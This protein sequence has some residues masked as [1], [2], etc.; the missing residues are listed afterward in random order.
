M[1]QQH[2]KNAKKTTQ[3]I[4]TLIATPASAQQPGGDAGGPKA[5]PKAVSISGGPE[6]GPGEGAMLRNLW[7]TLK[8]SCTGRITAKKETRGGINLFSFVNSE[9]KNMHTRFVHY[10]TYM[11]SIT[12]NNGAQ[13]IRW[14]YFS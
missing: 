14:I 10:D 1:Q 4:D 2:S 12:T 6:G 3:N 13:H 9:R 8:E 11:L 5:G 7:S